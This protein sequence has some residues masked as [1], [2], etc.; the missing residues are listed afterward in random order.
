MLTEK[1]YY[2]DCHLKT[3]IATVTGCEKVEKGWNITLSATAFYPE[4]GGQ[5]CD[6]GALGS[7]KVL[8]VREKGETIVHL[9]DAPL[10]V[11][12]TVEGNIDW[13][14]RFDLMQQHTG[15]HIV[16]G[17]LHEKFGCHNVGFHIGADVMEV[18]FDCNPTPQELAEIEGRANEIIWE[19]LPVECGFPA[20]EELPGIPYRSKKALE[21]PVRIVK[22]PGADTCACCGV[23]VKRTG[24]VG[25]IKILSCVKFH[26]GVRLQMVCGGRAYRYLSAVYEQAKQVSQ[27]FS[28]KIPEIGAAAVRMNDALAAEK[29]RCAALQKQVFDS[30]AMDYVNHNNVLHF[31]DDLNSGGVRELADKIADAVTGFAA[32]FSGND[33]E[34]YSYCLA[35]RSGDLRELGK[36]MNTA[37]SGR[38]GGKPEFQQGSVKAKKSEIETFFVE[39]VN[40][41]R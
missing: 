22:V 12:E 7:A 21:W 20:A 41:N 39:C 36:S 1:L 4:G 23:H 31:A 25:I 35:T 10:T 13:E 28:A 24:E 14:R 26:Q 27:A 38:G 11:G 30:V 6:L 15:E 18:D 29:F 19:N 9:C 16:S 17:L 5:A 3:F 37:L 33:E 2:N 32:V 34:G 8:D 40:S